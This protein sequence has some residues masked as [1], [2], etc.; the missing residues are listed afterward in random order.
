MATRT[1]PKFSLEDVVAT[2]DREVAERL[3]LQCGICY[4]LFHE[5]VIL[6][7]CSHVFCLD[8]VRQMTKCPLCNRPFE[9]SEIYTESDVSDYLCRQLGEVKVGMS[10][11]F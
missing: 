2:D 5:P 3:N 1:P 4:C 8:H 11:V 10:T 9:E 6:K 7:Q